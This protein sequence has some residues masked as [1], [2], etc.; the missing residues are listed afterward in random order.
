MKNKL[1]LCLALLSVL[2]VQAFAQ[3]PNPSIS[4]LEIYDVESRTHRVIKEFPFVVEAPNWTPDGKWLVVNRGG[5]L[6]KIAPD[7][8]TD[9]QEI[10]T[11]PLTGINNDHVIKVDGKWIG[12]SSN[13]PTSR[14]YNS[15][16]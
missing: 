15:Y 16:V 3:H 4:Y 5:K 10:P 2:T 9:L 11:G 13:D 6:Y 1:L 7:G 8:S 14:Q 12:L